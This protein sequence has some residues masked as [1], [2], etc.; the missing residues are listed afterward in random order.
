MKLSIEINGVEILNIKN[1]RQD[2]E[3]REIFKNNF[4]VA[5]FENRILSVG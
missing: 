4:E 1:D 3:K 2:G 5:T